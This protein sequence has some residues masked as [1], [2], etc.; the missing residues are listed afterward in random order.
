MPGIP[1]DILHPLLYHAGVKAERK[2]NARVHGPCDVPVNSL[3]LKDV[4]LI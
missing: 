1:L 3:P 4:V 2:G